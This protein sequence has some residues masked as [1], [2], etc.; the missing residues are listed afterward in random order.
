MNRPTLRLVKVPIFAPKPKSGSAAFNRA[1]TMQTE[2]NPKPKGYFV[3]AIGTDS[4]KTLIAALLCKALSADY[5]KPVQ[6][7]YPRDT[8]T[9]QALLHSM[10]GRWPGSTHPE[11][12]LLP[13]PES[14]HA[15]AAKAGINI[16]PAL[17]KLPET[18]NTIIAEGAGGLLVPITPHFSAADLMAQLQLPLILVCNLYLGSINHSLLTLSEIKH[19]KLP[20]AGIV[21]NGPAN[22]YSESIILENAGVS[23]L[24]RLPQL[25]ELSPETLSNAA[26]LISL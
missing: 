20:L 11:T 1:I 6:A 12:Y 25:P 5:W 13:T 17:F 18:Q 8:D 3:T 19:R 15:S 24:L 2:S 7:G 16:E 22:P 23:C 14:P 21:F 4:G 10:P 26:K 9:V